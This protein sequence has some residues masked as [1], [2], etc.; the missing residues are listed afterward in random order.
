MK[1][2]SNHVRNDEIRKKSFVFMIDYRKKLLLFDSIQIMRISPI[3]G[4]YFLS[5]EIIR[6]VPL[7][8]FAV[9]LR[10]L[11]SVYRPSKSLLF[12]PRNSID[13]N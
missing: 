8:Y 12:R 13:G 11:I 9:E 2:K 5:L 10:N 3:A 4:G 1:K 7:F 6:V